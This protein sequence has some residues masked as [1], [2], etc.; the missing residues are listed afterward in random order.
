MKNQ[1][2]IS[3]SLEIHFFVKKYF[4]SLMRI[5]DEQNSDPGYTSRIR[6][7]VENDA[8]RQDPDPQHR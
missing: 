1:E 6:N 3:Y 2:H 4:N 8:A 5:R 7:T